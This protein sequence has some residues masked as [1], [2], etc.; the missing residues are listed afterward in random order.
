[1]SN[2][3][4]HYLIDP[5][6]EGVKRL[7]DLP[8]KNNTD[9]KVNTKYHLST[10]EMTNYNVIIDWQNIFYQPVKKKLNIW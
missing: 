1:M 9:K 6:F 8:F 10:L 5:R 4:L 3:Y 7:F 2:L